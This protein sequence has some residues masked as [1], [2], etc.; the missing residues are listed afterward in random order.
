MTG[1]PSAL[2]PQPQARILT[3]TLNPALDLATQTA[4][5]VPELKLRCEAPDIDPG[6]G[7]INVSRAIARMDGDSTAVVALGGP[8]GARAR[9]RSLTCR[10]AGCPR[11]SWATPNGWVS[12]PPNSTSREAERRAHP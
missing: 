2:G 4:R 11:G 5:V 6:G 8:A 12:R 3:V 10:T 1:A 9:P 7:G